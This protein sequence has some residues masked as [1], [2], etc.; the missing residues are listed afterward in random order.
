MV[1]AAAVNGGT[2]AAEGAIAACL[3]SPICAAIAAVTGIS[4]ATETVL[5]MSPKSPR[6]EPNWVVRAGV[7][8][9]ASLQGGSAQH[10]AQPDLYGFSV[11]YMPGRS[12]E[13]LARA[14]RFP[15][16]QISVTTVEQLV[17]AGAAAGYNIAVVPSPGQGFHATVKVPDPMPD[18]LA[19]ALAGT[20]VGMPNPAQF[21]R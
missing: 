5:T 10:M 1:G 20:F 18:D 15:N 2:L 16:A 6:G 17:A 11:Q 7:A 19:V 3:R 9:P 21:G 12:V 14:G 8:T 4:I 13:E